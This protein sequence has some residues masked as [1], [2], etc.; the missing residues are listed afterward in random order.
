MQSKQ[1]VR[2]TQAQW[3]KLID[4]QARS[5][6]SAKQYCQQNALGYASFCKWRQ[7]LSSPL[8]SAQEPAT[9]PAFVD[10]SALQQATEPGWHITLKLGNG[11]ELVLSQR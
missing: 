2:R 8:R 7:R 4:D 9:E 11:V 3:Q 5:G 6:L 10:L 1:P